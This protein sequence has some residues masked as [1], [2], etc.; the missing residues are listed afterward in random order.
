MFK[1]SI[2]K[3]FKTAVKTFPVVILTGARQTG[4]STLCRTLL[5]KTHTYVSLEDPDVRRQAV[6]DP[7]TFLQNFPPPVIFD[8]IQYAPDLPSYIQGLVDENRTAYGQFI[9]T[10]SQNFLLMEKVSQ[11]LAGRAALLT[12]YPCRVAEVDGEKAKP[13]SSPKAVADWIL[14]GGYPELRS[15]PHLDRKTWCSSYI[16][17]YLERDV[18]QI[19]QIGDLR[20]FERFIHLLAMRTGQMLNLSDLAR[21]VGISVPTASRWLTVLE[22]S[23]QIFILPPFHANLPKRLI[24]SPKIYFADTALASYLMGIHDS[25]T[26][27]QGPFLG[28]LFETATVLEHLKWQSI[29]AN[30]S[31]LTYFRTK[32]GV[33]VDLIIEDGVKLRA[34]EIKATRTLNTFSAENL[35]KTGHLLKKPLKEKLILAPLE[36]PIHVSKEVLVRPW[37]HVEW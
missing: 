10:G 7:R 28:P 9:L 19:L 15:R 32:D 33:E 17:L 36:K 34:R 21:D 11:S 8:E 27:L 12:L 24:K 20:N 35:I 13:R 30:G 1:R 2:E 18:R 6:E 5:K 4:K 37:H 14:R 23:Y 29:H 22:A 25:E 3:K 16:Q 31:S 26:L